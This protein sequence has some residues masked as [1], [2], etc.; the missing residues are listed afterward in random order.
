MLRS[1]LIIDY[2]RSK[3]PDGKF[4]FLDLENKKVTYHL[5]KDFTDYL[6]DPEE[7]VRAFYII[8]L[9][10]ENEFKS[11]DMEVERE[12]EFQIGRGEKKSRSDIII[13]KG[14]LPFI[15]FETKPPTEYEREK[16]KSIRGQL[17]GV[18]VNTDTE[19]LTWLVYAT[20]FAEEEILEDILVID[21][22]IFNSFEKWK[23]AQEPSYSQIPDIQGRFSKLLIKGK[24]KL[25]PLNMEH[26]IKI[27]QKLH[28][29][30]WRGGTRADNK[31]FF[32]LLKLVIAK[33]YDEKE[34]ENDKPYKFQLYYTQD[35]VNYEKINEHVQELYKKT[36]QDS[37]YL[38]LKE[39]KLKKLSQIEA[40]T[41]IVELTPEEI[42][43]IVS[44]FQRYSLQ[45]TYDVLSIFFETIIREE[46]KQSTGLYFTP[47]N[48][49][50]FIVFGLEI[51][52]LSKDILKETKSSL[53]YII[54]P[55]CGS[56]TFLVEAMKLI[57]STILENKNNIAVTNSIKEFIE[58]N[59]DE[60][61]QRHIWAQKFLYGMDNHPHLALTTK[62][63]MVMNGDG[64]VHI[65]AD[66]A[67]DDFVEYEDLLKKTHK[68]D[69]YK[70]ILNEQF[71]VVVSNP[72]F[73]MKLDPA[74]KE[75][76]R[77]HFPGL[78]NKSS[79]ILFLERW[80]QLLKPNGRL[81]VV[82]PES[83]FDTTENFDVRL[84]LFRFFWIKAIISLPGGMK[85][86]AF[87]PYTGT[88]T[89]LLFL[90]KKT[91]EEV[92]DYSRVWEKKSYEFLALR[93][94]IE[95]YFG[96]S[97]G[98]YHKNNQKTIQ[99]FSEKDKKD[100]ITLLR[101]FI[102]EL[103]D[104]KD[105]RIE[106]ED[107]I[108]KYSDDIALVSSIGK[109][110]WV[111]RY[112]SEEIEK[113]YPEWKTKTLIMHTNDIGYKRTKIRHYKTENKLFKQEDKNI[114]INTKEPET[115]LDFM[116]GL[117]KWE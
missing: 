77:E 16:Y 69:V 26:V 12:W 111:F 15:I 51:D 48:L 42:A 114:I 22:K 14:E 18:S 57:T 45:T 29:R 92:E 71:D 82:L 117:V 56:G 94:Q 5:K 73:S 108:E 50:R 84:F 33:I 109:H 11:K 58:E 67:L 31:I 86:G 24:D 100:F 74:V 1:S 106:I 36:L 28:N 2:I 43:F 7:Y 70:G 21:F 110:W 32:N 79:E 23:K 95:K 83:I 112:V 87:S 6:D 25:I 17:Y 85:D 91:K 59:F 3:D 30:L 10:F 116:R 107:L 34:S 81:G 38:D 44:E 103:F 68:N 52:K 41:E 88:T 55:S 54:D 64:H 27:K 65:F 20:I 104:E 99:G 90:Q 78:G 66:D 61:G 39:E 62:V 96:K 102:L 53:P 49:V 46:F 40:G 89:S 80:Y 47:I 76:Y 35:S 60:N 93:K 75:K 113:N 115:V 13:Y 4:V 98:R 37:R 97:K 9:I 63:N 72:P 105:E 8:K 101:K 19:K